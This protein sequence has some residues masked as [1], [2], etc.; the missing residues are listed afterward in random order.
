MSAEQKIG[1]YAN[2]NR[3]KAQDIIHR[4]DFDPCDYQGVFGLYLRAYDDVDLAHRQRT[5]AMKNLVDR[6]TAAAA[7]GR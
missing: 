3:V 1:L 5:K 2:L 6:E 4:G 7:A